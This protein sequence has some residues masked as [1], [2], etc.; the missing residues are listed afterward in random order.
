VV[1]WERDPT[2]AGSLLVW[3]S[4]DGQVD[5]FQLA[6]APF[7]G[8]REYFAGWRRGVSLRV[9]EVDPGDAAVGDGPRPKM[10]PVVRSS[11]RPSESVLLT[12]RDYFD[13]RAIAL[14]AQH[15]EQIAAVLDEAARNLE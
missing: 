12:L 11:P 10:S 14:D 15:R 8:R 7:P 5:Q 9:G 1:Y 4:G 3:L 6:Y 13:R 2:E